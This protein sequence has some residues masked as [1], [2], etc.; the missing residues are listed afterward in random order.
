LNF[1]ATFMGTPT[2]LAKEREWAAAAMRRRWA[3]DLLGIRNP[4]G[5]AGAQ[6][7]LRGRS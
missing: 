2:F 3:G 5:R 4:S 1:L 7:R 6:T